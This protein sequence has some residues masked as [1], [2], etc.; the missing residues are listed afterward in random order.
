MYSATAPASR[1]L[2]TN[3]RILRSTAPSFFICTTVFCSFDT[4][5]RTCSSTP[6]IL[7]EQSGRIFPS[8]IAATKSCTGNRALSGGAC[9]HMSPS[10]MSWLFSSA[11]SESGIAGRIEPESWKSNES[12]GVL[13]EYEVEAALMSESCDEGCTGFTRLLCS[14]DAYKDGFDPARCRLLLSSWGPAKCFA[15]PDGRVKPRLSQKQSATVSTA[16]GLNCRQTFGCN[17]DPL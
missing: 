7:T 12:G 5:F 2:A 15:L 6:L 1:L 3:T 14:E 9:E 4:F 17:L 13:P 11:E 16:T 10:T 8:A